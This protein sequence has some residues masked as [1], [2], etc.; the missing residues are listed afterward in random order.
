MSRVT[1]FKYWKELEESGAL[2]ATRQIGR[3]TMYKIDRAN[4]M[5]KTITEFERKLSMQIAEQEEAK[6]QH[7]IAA[8]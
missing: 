1:F 5:I 3:A 7:P 6:T 2:K 8:T 4:P